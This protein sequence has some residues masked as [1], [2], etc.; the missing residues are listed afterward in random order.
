MKYLFD[1]R[2][3]PASKDSPTFSR[4]A[5]T[6]SL[7]EKGLIYVSCGSDLGGYP[8]DHP[9]F[10]L[11]FEGKV[12]H[13]RLRADPRFILGLEK[14]AIGVKTGRSI[15]LFCTEGPPELCHRSTAIG[16]ALTARR[17]RVVHIDEDDMEISQAEIDARS[18]L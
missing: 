2:R 7:S 17:L 4:E 9:A 6:K 12:R 8:E 18:M 16:V 11:D 3:V 5:L 10:F 14:L 15:A 13:A 1:I